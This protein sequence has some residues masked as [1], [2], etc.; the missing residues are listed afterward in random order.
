[1]RFKSRMGVEELRPVSNSD[2]VQFD[3][4]SFNMKD[5][6][7][8]HKLQEALFRE[9]RHK[10]SL[11]RFDSNQCYQCGYHTTENESFIRSLLPWD[12]SG[13]H[14]TETDCLKYCHFCMDTETCNSCMADE[15]VY[16]PREINLT[17]APKKRR[18]CRFAYDELLHHN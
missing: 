5:G 11:R 18:V 4:F 14:D 6:I 3:H 16:V 9:K 15:L 12:S 10:A 13:I 1:M 8:S 2:I 7:Y 17:E